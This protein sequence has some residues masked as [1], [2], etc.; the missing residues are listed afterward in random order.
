MKFLDEKG[1]W[2]FKSML[3][4]NKRANYLDAIK[5]IHLSLQEIAPDAAKLEYS[6]QEDAK[7]RVKAGITQI[8]VQLDLLEKNL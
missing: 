6:N 7:N 2:I 1:K 8:Q 3:D 5:Q 4:N